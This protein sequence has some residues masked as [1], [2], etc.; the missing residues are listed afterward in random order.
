[1]SAQEHGAGGEP[2]Q[3]EHHFALTEERRAT[4][5]A[6]ELAASMGQFG[7]S[8]N[9]LENETSILSQ[10]AA[11]LSALMDFSG[12][13]MLLADEATFEFDIA[14]CSHPDMR[15]SFRRET[16]LLIEDRTFAWALGRNKPSVVTTQMGKMLLHPL[17]TASGPLGMFAG[18][19][20]N[21]P[22]ERGDMA[23]ISH[24]LIT[25]ALFASA[26]LLENFRLY[27]HLEQVNTTLE[28]Q[29]AERTRELTDSNTRLRSTLAEKEHYRQ[30]LEAVFSSM[31]DPLITVDR[32]RRILSVNRAGEAF[33]GA[34]AEFVAGRPFHEICRHATAACLQVFAST[35]DQGQTVREFRTQYRHE[36]MDKALVLSCSPLV[37]AGGTMDGAV[38]LIRDIT[39]LASLERQ[40]KER[41][42]FRSIVG[43]SA[44]MQQLYTLL[45]NLAEVDTTVLVTGESG[46]GKELVAD[47]LH[48]NGPRAAGPLVKVNCT[49]LSE[50]LLES[51]LFGHVRGAFT[52]AVSNRAGRFEAAEGGTI[53]L[54]EIGDISL[55]IQVLLL[56]FL[57][58]KEFERVGDTATRKADVRIV[59]ATNADLLRKV[60]E[61]SFRADLYY[62]LNVMHVHLPPLRER[63]DDIPLLISHFTEY[64]NR[65]LKTEIEGV[66]DD[67][68]HFFMR[69][70]WSGNVREL[71]HAVEHACI[72]CR[73]GTIGMEHL[74]PE[75]L[76]AASGNEGAQLMPHPPFLQAPGNHGY[77]PLSPAFPS[78]APPSFTGESSAPHHGPM[79]GRTQPLQP[80]S[81]H[82]S[83]SAKQAYPAEQEYMA[84]L[85]N[86]PHSLGL[87]HP[88]YLSHSGRRPA[89]HDL[90]AQDIANAIRAAHGNKA[91]A[92]RL[93][94]IGRA[95]LYRKMR[96]LG[97][98]Y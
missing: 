21:E 4:L 9:E 37:S 96:E 80:D 44:R 2:S 61:G 87:S 6:L 92:A 54:D 19:L 60:R 5:R 8:L 25:V 68:M 74:T 97:L 42:S 26:T 57:E 51:E 71:K 39:R 3:H 75:I 93:L 82:L 35:I 24:Y 22:G 90:S 47:A 7:N 11:K 53:F 46:T 10:T 31:Q 67:A 98:D 16:A 64:F 81:P 12:I 40:L 33:F 65:T 85:H 56:R 62:R 79:N 29:V 43:K 77:A 55:R 23:D 52:G 66:S 73:T 70:P 69:H 30:N 34:G 1:M 89:F 91:H 20:G 18:I 94:G 45:E 58:S 86:L 78:A 63:R 36:G 50:S 83:P 88:P 28:E 72:L 84:G 76:T 32:Q 38:L 15:E 48:H 27:R 49:A 13:C 41:H 14:W 95:T 17:S 59:A